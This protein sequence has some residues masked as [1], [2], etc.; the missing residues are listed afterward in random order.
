M[1]SS[2]Y[3]QGGFTVRITFVASQSGLP[4]RDGACIIFEAYSAEVTV[5]AEGNTRGIAKCC[6]SLAN[7]TGQIVL[8]IYE[9][10]HRLLHACELL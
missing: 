7:T 4:E 9:R 1:L 2:R 3:A 8:N 10:A 5:D 6:K